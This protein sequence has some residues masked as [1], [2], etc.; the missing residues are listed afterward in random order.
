M[1]QNY[2][3]LHNSENK[4]FKCEIFEGST[5][6]RLLTA[7]VIKFCSRRFRLQCRDAAKITSEWILPSKNKGPGADKI[8]NKLSLLACAQHKISEREMQV[9]ELK[10]SGKSKTKIGEL[11]FISPGT[12]KKHLQNG[13]KKLRENS[14]PG[15]F[16]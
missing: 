6:F 9:L 7:I 15:T 11:L 10:L 5:M 13:Y 3:W 14:S 12:V 8:E 2:M 1:Y 16:I 4:V